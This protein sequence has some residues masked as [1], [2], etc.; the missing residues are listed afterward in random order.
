M[1]WNERL[2][3]QQHNFVWTMA[4]DLVDLLDPQP[5]QKVLDLGC[6]TGA[7]TAQIHQSGADVL[8]I[9]SSTTMIESARQQFPDVR[10]RIHDAHGL[11]FENE[12]DAV[13]SNA[14]LHWMQTPSVVVQQIAESLKSG[15]RLVAEFGGHG[16]IQSIVDAALHA[17]RSLQITHP[18]FEGAG[19]PWYFPTVGQFATLLEQNGLL[20][21]QAALFER[22]TPLAG[23]QGLTDWARMFGR[24]WLDA[25]PDLQQMQWLAEFE[26]AASDQLRQEESWI[27]DYCRIRIVAQKSSLKPKA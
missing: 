20:V 6:G 16:N 21:Q 8:G 24:H 7:L 1:H 17:A 27:A 13:F 19:H 3:N 4:A 11:P 22:P 26:A 15:G 14:A 9:D 2:Y 5:R 12:F 18:A 23:Q 10:F 25:V